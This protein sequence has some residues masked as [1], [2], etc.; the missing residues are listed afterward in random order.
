MK[1]WLPVIALTA[2]C[3][4]LSGCGS[5]ESLRKSSTSSTVDQ[6]H[7]VALSQVEKAFNPSA[8]D[9][10]IEV[11]QKQHEFEQQRATTDRK[12]VV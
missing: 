5:S 6:D 10:E 2:V 8:Y 4:I 12:S 7:K 3:L 9:D 11:I 1:R